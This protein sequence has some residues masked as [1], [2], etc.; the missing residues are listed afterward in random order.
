MRP[1]QW[2]KNG[3]V[4]APLVFAGVFLDADSV[5]YGLFATLLFCIASSATILNDLHDIE[6]DRR[7]PKKSKTRP[8]ASGAVS[9]RAALVLL[10][11][12]Y[13]CAGLVCCPSRHASDCRLLV[14]NIAYTFL[15][16]RSRCRHLH[17]GD[18]FCSSRLCGSHSCSSASLGLDVCN[19]ALSSSLLSS[20]K[21]R[22]QELNQSGVEGR[23]VLEKYSVA[24]VDK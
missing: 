24:L 19:N 7:H 22:R 8:L 10:I 13:P 5:R 4:L 6:K 15:E 18:G 2:L 12:Y 21:K 14:L 17:A 16:E 20:R 3:F 1:K 9:K 11:P 23:K